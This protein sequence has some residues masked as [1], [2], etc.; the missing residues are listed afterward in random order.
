[1]VRSTAACH[2]RAV[3]LA[4]WRS[5]SRAEKPKHDCTRTR[6][7]HTLGRAAARDGA[8]KQRCTHKRRTLRVQ[9]TIARNMHEA[10]TWPSVMQAV[11]SQYK[12]SHGLSTHVTVPTLPH[13]TSARKASG[14][15]K[16]GVAA[17]ASKLPAAACSVCGIFSSCTATSAAAL[18]SAPSL[19]PPVR[20]IAQ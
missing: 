13:A 14:A 18:A 10:Q 16:D 5:V 2:T 15:R 17:T 4:R 3:E 12:P 11:R 7:S 20:T 6:A 19:A 9:T 1:M 8:E